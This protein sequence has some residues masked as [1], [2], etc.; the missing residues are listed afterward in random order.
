MTVADPQAA[1]LAHIV[2]QTESNVQFLVSNNYM[3]AYDASGFLNKLNNIGP[4]QNV[5]L[6]APAAEAPTVKARAKWAYNE[7][8]EVSYQL[9][10]T[11]AA[12]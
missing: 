6:S 9:I 2:A 5:V 12:D 1:L 3:S 7:H 11:L 10:S 8:G 4:S